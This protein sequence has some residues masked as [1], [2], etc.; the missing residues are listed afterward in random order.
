MKNVVRACSVYSKCGGMSMHDPFRELWERAWE[1][2][3]M[4]PD[5]V[6]LYLIHYNDVSSVLVVNY[7]FSIG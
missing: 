5:M 6:S 2:P 7:F 1:R 4:K 3:S